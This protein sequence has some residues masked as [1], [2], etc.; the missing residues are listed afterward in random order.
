MRHVFTYCMQQQLS[1]AERSND[2]FLSYF[3]LE[4]CGQRPLK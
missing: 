1:L 2:M 4:T 3:R